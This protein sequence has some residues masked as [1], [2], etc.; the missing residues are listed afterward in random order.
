MRIYVFCPPNN[1]NES[2][3]Q[4]CIKKSQMLIFMKYACKTHQL[5][6]KSLSRLAITTAE[7][8]ALFVSGKKTYVVLLKWKEHSVQEVIPAT[9]PPFSCTTNRLNGHTTTPPVIATITSTH[10]WVLV[11]A[12]LTIIHANKVVV[13]AR[14]LVAVKP[15]LVRGPGSRVVLSA[16]RVTVGWLMR[17]HSG[18]T[19]CRVGSGEHCGCCAML[20]HE[21]RRVRPRKG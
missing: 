12:E 13:S 7:R 16:L 5:L 15:M 18:E 1:F 6:S 17:M 20:K 14:I 10:N 8:V 3:P 4:K 11:I 9:F 19:G 2:S 21:P